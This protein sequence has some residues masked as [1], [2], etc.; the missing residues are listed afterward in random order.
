MV[1]ITPRGLLAQYLIGA[2]VAAA[3]GTVPLAAWLDNAGFPDLAVSVQAAGATTGFDR[4]YKWLHEAM[5]TA[6]TAQFPGSR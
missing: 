6:E 3:L 5:K 2:A 4:P 1:N